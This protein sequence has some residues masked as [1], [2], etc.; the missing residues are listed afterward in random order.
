VSR[1]IGGNRRRPALAAIIAATLTTPTIATDS[2]D[3]L[4]QVIV[5]GARRTERTA[6][7]SNVPVDVVS[8]DSLQSVFNAD[9]NF[10]LEALIPS[11]NVRRI[12][13][14]DGAIFVRPASLRNLSPDHTLVLLNGKRYHRSAFVDITG[15]VRGAQA[16]D[17]SLLPAIAFK[18]V[19]VLRDGAAAQYGSDAIAGVVNFIVDDAPGTSA[20]AQYGEFT[21]GSGANLQVGASSGFELGATGHLNLAAEYVDG[22]ASNT[23]IQRPNAT[24]IEAQGEPYASAARR[25]AR[26]GVVQRYGQP[27][28]ES[29]KLV[30]SAGLE[31]GSAQFYTFGNFADQTGVGDFNYRAPLTVTGPDADGNTA[32]FYRNGGYNIRNLNG[33][34]TSAYDAAWRLIDVYPGGFTPRFGSDTRD[35]SLVTGISG[36]VGEHLDWDFSASI[37]SNR[38]QYW[39]KESI[40]LS[41]GPNSPTDF[42]DAGSREQRDRNLNLDFVYQWKTALANPVNVGFGVE[43]R[44][45]QFRV[46]AGEAA[47]WVMGPLRDM[48]PGANGF[49]AAHPGTA[50]VWSSRS[51]GAYLEFDADI[52]DRLNVTLAGRMEDFSLFGTTTD[53]KLASRF[54][55]TD[56]VSLR[57]SVSTGFRAPTPGQQYLYNIS[58]G[59]NLNPAIP[60]SVITSGQLPPTSPIAMLLGATPLRPEKSVNLSL[61]LVLQP[62][63]GVAITLDA[64]QVD[65]DDRFGVSKAFNLDNPA[66]VTPAQLAQ[67]RASDEPFAA[68]LSYISFFINNFDTRTTGID[69]VGAWRG[70]AG[71]GQLALTWATNY[72]ESKYRDYDPALL[73]EHARVAFLR[74]VPRFASHLTAEYT[75]GKWHFTGRA[76]HFGTWIYTENSIQKISAE[77]FLDLTADFAASD[78]VNLTIGIENAFD[79]YADKVQSTALRNVGRQYP[80]GTPY[81]NEGRQIYAR[82]GIRF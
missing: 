15:G 12:P 27:D 7:E 9:L 61:G 36:D 72:N 26:D 37:G 44:R 11:Y 52:T 49:V 30:A 10:K 13:T 70:A 47:A 75:L 57:G 33:I 69:L 46:R 58:Q 38:I 22:K 62:A 68:E 81:E 50:G 24:L 45:E 31:L 4:D 29:F 71:P 39:M 32:T 82:M 59:P 20:Y 28:L 14:D 1:F 8:G 64:Y 53:G 23:G 43:Y 60:L 18:R 41:L 35:Y 80:G 65:I 40:N 56:A 74:S 66:D 2:A 77:T 78:T 55:I 16:P 19:E 63:P 3:E 67:I 48:S 17:L 25:V 79:N 51:T 5:T 6:L 34:G 42:P 21:K 73:S 76:R 54:G